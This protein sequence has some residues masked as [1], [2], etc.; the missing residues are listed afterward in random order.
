MIQLA[1]PN[2]GAPELA[3]LAATVNTNYVGPGGGF[4]TKFEEMV[5]RAAQRKW[6]IAVVTGSVAL[7]V[8]MEMLIPAGATVQVGRNAFPAAKNSL[9]RLEAH[10]VYNEG[11]ADHDYA[12]YQGTHCWASVADCAP[13]IG[14]ERTKDTVECYSFAA[15]K[16]VTCGQ[17]GAIVGDDPGLEE[18]LRAR[19]VQ[20]YG[21]PEGYNF[22][23]ANVNAAMGCAQMDQLKE[24]RARK[25]EIWDR[26]ADHFPMVGRGPSRWMSTVRFNRVPVKEVQ[27]LLKVDGIESRIEP[28]GI[29]IPCG[30]GLTDEEQ[31]K[32]IES[33][34]RILTNEEHP[35]HHDGSRRCLASLSSY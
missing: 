9:E 23:M 19:I 17:G 20:G 21:M 14:N 12:R 27:D 35:R 3:N 26:Y 10:I 29:S 25:V 16:I 28:C 11:G 31:T 34:K 5:A 22:R 33:L 4:V 24:F 32:V 7:G 6:A 15:N 13:A 1:P 2:L 8:S 18:Q 30:T